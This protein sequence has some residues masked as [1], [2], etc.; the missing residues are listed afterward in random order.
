VSTNASLC[1]PH[2]SSPWTVCCSTS[3]APVEINPSIKLLILKHQQ[4]LAKL[5]KS[6][7][8]KHIL[9][10]KNINVNIEH[11]GLLL[12]NYYDV[13]SLMNLLYCTEEEILSVYGRLFKILLER[14]IFY[15]VLLQSLKLAVYVMLI[16]EYLEAVSYCAKLSNPL[17]F[18]S[19]FWC[20][21]AGLNL[22]L[23]L[24]VGRIM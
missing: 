11:P 18:G 16:I 7:V 12:I 19:T 23:S 6:N 22:S 13:Q 21:T 8:N 2:R 24:H 15:Y 10:E 9:I 14:R 1:H 4:T 5:L 3:S 20:T 17:L